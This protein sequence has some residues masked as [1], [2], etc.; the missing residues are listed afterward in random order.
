MKSGRRLSSKSRTYLGMLI[1]VVILFF[2]FNTLPLIIGAFYSF[3]NYRGYGSWDQNRKS[4]T[5][6]TTATHWRKVP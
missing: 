1:P 2:A 5:G 6:R 4:L 3:T